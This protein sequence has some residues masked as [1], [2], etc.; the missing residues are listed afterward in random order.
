MVV[1]YHI[2]PLGSRRL[3]SAGGTTMSQK[4]KAIDCILDWNLWPRHEFKKIDITN[5]R[6][7]EMSL[8]SGKTLP[9]IVVNASDMRVVDGFHRVKAHLNVFGDEATID[10]NLKEY[11]TESAMFLDA[12]AL[13]VHQGLQLSPRD[14]A[15][16]IIRLRQMKVPPLVIAETLG[17]DVKKMK[18]FLESRSAYT[19]EGA[20]ISVSQGA[21]HL[22]VAKR[23]EKALNTEQ[24]KLVR[25]GPS[26]KPMIYVNMLIQIFKA[27]A[28]PLSDKDK[29]RLTMLRD[30]INEVL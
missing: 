9:A 21:E 30:L 27:D 2:F 16:S 7:M 22:S 1:V 23:G 20:R 24:E 6:Q 18:E 17:M 11:E 13:N 26:M 15:H 14:R 28:L 8:E 10:A 12:V 19:K 4:I 25:M 3:F 5:R 29:E